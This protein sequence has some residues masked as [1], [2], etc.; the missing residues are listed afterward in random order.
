MHGL[1]HITYNNNNITDITKTSQRHNRHDANSLQR[2]YRQETSD[3]IQQDTVTI[4]FRDDDNRNSFYFIKVSLE[5]KKR[6]D[7]LMNIDVLFS[8]KVNDPGNPGLRL[9]AENDLHGVSYSPDDYEDLT[10]RAEALIDDMYERV[11]TKA[12]R[13]K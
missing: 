8:A 5:H 2:Q 6:C 1:I 11:F 10:E 9:V 12:R 4:V 13:K 3:M 7:A